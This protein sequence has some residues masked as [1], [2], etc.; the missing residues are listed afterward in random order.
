MGPDLR[1]EVLQAAQSPPSAIGGEISPP[2]TAAFT[3]LRAI[4]DTDMTS[5]CLLR[6]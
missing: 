3:S 6:L 4:S 1:D 2:P 5:P